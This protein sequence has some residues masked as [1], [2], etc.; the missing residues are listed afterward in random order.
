MRIDVLGGSGGIAAGHYTTA[1]AIGDDILVDAGS[2]V[3]TLTRA[4]LL[5]LRRVF[6]SH[7]HLDHVAFLPFLIDS[8]FVSQAFRDGVQL[9]VY[10]L[11]ETLEDLR[12][13]LFNGAIWPD[14]T[15]LPSAENPIV[16]F[17]EMQYW[18][19]L[20]VAS[21][22]VPDLTVTA[23]PADHGNAACGF[24]FEGG[25]QRFAYTGDTGLGPG[26]QDAWP[27]LGPVDILM[28]EC[29]LP[30]RLDHLAGQAWHLT[31]ERL[32]GLLASMDPAPSMVWIGH[33]KPGHEDEIRAELSIALPAS[34][35][36]RT[37]G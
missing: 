3:G 13:H 7:A 16:V 23:F 36:W 29:A 1:I 20:P 32:A 28:T 35:Q 17:R 31:P 34:L 2:G 18:E 14:F 11:P 5:R 4:Q 25:G 8:L 37:V 24:L 27:R 15:V 26:V 33:M 22:Q 6:L 9:Q 30:N 10:A 12:R 21:E 19:P